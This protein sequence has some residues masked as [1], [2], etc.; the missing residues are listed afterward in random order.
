MDVKDKITQQIYS[1]QTGRCPKISSQG[2]QYIV[3]IAGVD[4]DTILMEPMRNRS[5]GEMVQTW[6]KIL[7]RLAECGIKSKH[8]ILNNKISGEYKQA[9]KDVD[10]T[11]E[12][13]PPHDY[14]R[15]RAEKAI[16]TGRANFISILCGVSPNFPLH[17]WDRLLPQTEMM[18]NI[19]RPPRL[20]PTISVH[21]Y[22]YGQHDYN[23]QPLA[24]LGTAVEIHVKPTAR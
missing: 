19:L 6:K 21:A 16:Q 23:R 22:L 20:V 17:L 18:L 7:E 9:I 1:D 2:N 11:Y 24:Q 5:A 12:L 10:M 8:Q 4:S 13:V 3:V 14:H 15:N